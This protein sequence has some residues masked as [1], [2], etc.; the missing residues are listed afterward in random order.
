[1]RRHAH[2]L[3]DEGV[4]WLDGLP[5]V[6]DWCAWRWSLRIG[7][8]LPSSYS[9]VVEAGRPDGSDA[10]LKVSFPE[11]EQAGEA[12]GLRRWD[13]QGA[14]RL[15]ESDA[16]RSALLIE[17][18][19]PGSPLWEAPEDEALRVVLGLLPRLWVR[20]QRADGFDSAA[21]IA[22]RWAT[23][24]PELHARAGAPGEP[25]LV[26]RAI[27]A[28]RELGPSQRHL[29]LVHRDFHGS[30]VLSA[31]REPWLVIDPKPTVAEREF[32]AA[33]Y[34]GDRS[35]TLT[36]LTAT[37]RLDAFASELGLDRERLRLWALARYVLGGLWSYD[38]GGNGSWGIEVARVY[39]GIR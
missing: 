7:A 18:C 4:A 31:T 1:V 5:A 30:N 36:T 23:E 26:D 2:R 19:V 37:R 38:G 3:G 35:E 24:L 6:V 9:V 39:A 12:E 14:V 28:F 32:D 20:G 16:E 22:A 34:L 29:V 11:P 21:E 10:I 33:W 25:A 8:I 17:R 13:G 27:E 15:L